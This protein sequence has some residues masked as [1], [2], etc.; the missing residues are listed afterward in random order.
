[1]NVPNRNFG[2]LINIRDNNTKK[3]P[4]IRTMMENE[5]FE[6]INEERIPL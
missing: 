6:K 5:I 1:M 2:R 4:E 3:I